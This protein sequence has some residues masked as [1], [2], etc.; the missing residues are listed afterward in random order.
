MNSFIYDHG[1][2]K[3]YLENGKVTVPYN[4]PE[5]K[6]GLKYL[7]KL[8]AEGLIDPQALTQDN[9]QLKKA[10][11]EPGYSHSWSFIRA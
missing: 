11:R 9:N 10:G 1:D 3:L 5:W 8:Y 2:K 6:E 7:R 4:K